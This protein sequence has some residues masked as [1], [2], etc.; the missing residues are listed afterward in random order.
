MTGRYP[1]CASSCWKAATTRCR[2]STTHLD[3]VLASCS[4]P[5]ALKVHGTIPACLHCSKMPGSSWPA[6]CCRRPMPRAGGAG[7][8]QAGQGQGRQH[9]AE[10]R[11]AAAGGAA[12]RGAAL[13]QA[14]SSTWPG[15]SRPKRNSASP[16]WPASISAPRPP[17]RSRRPRCCAC[18]RRR[19]TSAAPARAASARRRPRSCSR[20]WPA[21]RRR[22]RCRRR[23][24]LGRRT[25]R[26][27]LPARHP[28]AAVQD[29]VQAGQERAR[30]QGRGRGLARHAH[31][32][33]GLL[34]KAGAITRPT[35][36]TGSAS[37]WSTSPRAPASR[38][39][40]RPRSRTTCRGAPVQAFSID[41]SSTTE[42]DDALSVQGLGTGTV[43]VGVHIARP[44][45]PCSP[46]RA[47]GPVARQ[48]LST[49][50]MPG[51]RSPCCPTTWCRPTRCW[52]AATA[53]P[54]RCTSV[55]RGHAGSEGQRD[56][57]GARAD[58]RQPA[59]R[60][61]RRIVTEA[62]LQARRCRRRDV[63]ERPRAFAPEL[64]FLFRLAST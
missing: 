10:V 42:I 11:Q 6:G 53:P 27:Q 43:T 4:W 1:A 60:P 19:T 51:T 21:S 5:V 55:R 57:A 18:S 47:A 28:R 45:W 56:A 50:Y 7:K 20:R 58:R 34:Q 9:P 3:E 33:A 25:G 26:R 38:R 2:T 52:K 14:S 62:W 61:A 40:R 46:A 29:P 48:R 15:S 32:A 39:W 49:V 24:R 16:T 37:C 8:R 36:S 35:S 13:A 54:C 63:P 64:S 30:I 44:A 59:P 31:R 22:S 23:S 41:D 12:A 17:W